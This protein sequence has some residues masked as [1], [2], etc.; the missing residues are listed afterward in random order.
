MRITNCSPFPRSELPAQ[1]WSCDDPGL[2]RHNR[3]LYRS[4]RG[5]QSL[6]HRV[7]YAGVLEIRADLRGLTITWQ[8]V[9]DRIT[10][11][12]TSELSLRTK[13]QI[14]RAC[15]KADARAVHMNGIRLARLI[16]GKN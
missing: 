14:Y 16:G 5:G 8:T 1:T 12:Q 6:S 15:V 4:V 10:A 2:L 3:D 7:D 13:A 9:A 11:T